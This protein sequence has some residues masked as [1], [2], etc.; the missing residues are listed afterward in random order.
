LWLAYPLEAVDERVLV[1]LSSNAPEK[2]EYAVDTVEV[3]E[4][5]RLVGEE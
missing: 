2:F 1:R 4:G 3:F 5:C